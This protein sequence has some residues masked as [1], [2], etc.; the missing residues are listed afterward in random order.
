MKFL[1]IKDSNEG[2]KEYNFKAFPL[3]IAC[4][5]C[6]ALI[7]F[8]GYKIGYSVSNSSNENKIVLDNQNNKE[9]ENIYIQKLSDLDFIE[10]RQEEIIK[11]DNLLRSMIGLP[12]I[13]DDIYKMGTGGFL[14]PANDLIN[15][16][17]SDIIESIDHFKKITNLE[18]ISYFD[19]SDHINKNLNKVL[20]IPAIHPVAM[21]EC[22]MSSGY[23]KRMHPTLNRIHMH[24]GHDFAPINNFWNTEVNATADGRVKKS[25]YLPDTYGH[26]I[27]IDHGNGIVTAYAHLR[28]RNVR[29]GQQV[30]RG[31]KVGIMGSTGMSTSVHLH[32]EVKK[33]GR[34]IDP[35]QYYFDQT[36]L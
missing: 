28:V 11:K 24:D 34:P 8:I 33:N 20:S 5:A 32:Y 27:E 6:V 2:F 19:I 35:S 17:D 21:D 18:S 26:Y 13:H 10:K 4:L 7:S 31:Q 23:G 9:K 3:S 30:K 22:K 36:S 1:Y 12:Q 14:G 15:E 29:K 25:I 16:V